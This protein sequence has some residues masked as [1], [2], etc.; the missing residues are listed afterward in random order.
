MTVG[1]NFIS[2]RRQIRLFTSSHFVNEVNSKEV[3]GGQIME[4]V[5]KLL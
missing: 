4:M 5:S 1:E 3:L 2:F